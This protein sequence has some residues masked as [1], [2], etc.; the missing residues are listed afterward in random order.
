[1]INLLP[2]VVEGLDLGVAEDA[3]V[4]AQV[5]EGAVKVIGGGGDRLAHVK[6]GARGRLLI[7]VG[8]AGVLGPV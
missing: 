1:M 2:Q 6:K 3:V 5:V 4:D 7:P 8:W